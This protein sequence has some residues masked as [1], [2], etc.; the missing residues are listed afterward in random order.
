MD[1]KTQQIVLSAWEKEETT[2]PHKLCY[3]YVGTESGCLSVYKCCADL[4]IHGLHAQSQCLVCLMHNTSAWISH[5]PQRD[6]CRN[7]ACL[8][9]QP[10]VDH[11]A[12]VRRV[13]SESWLTWKQ[14]RSNCDSKVS[15]SWFWECCVISSNLEPNVI[16]IYATLF[17][18]FE[19]IFHLG[20]VFSFSP[21][22]LQS[23]SAKDYLTK[24]CLFFFFFLSHC[25]IQKILAEF[26]EAGGKLPGKDACTLHMTWKVSPERGY[27]LDWVFV[28]WLHLN[29]Q[30][31]S[32]QILPWNEL[33]CL[34]SCCPVKLHFIS[35]YRN[36]PKPCF[37]PWSMPQVGRQSLLISLRGKALLRKVKNLWRT[38]HFGK[39]KTL[40][41]L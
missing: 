19:C 13:S 5:M 26:S 36:Y 27:S 24:T 14:G 17:L 29:I 7:V 3:L 2:H 20:R 32:W 31:L 39:K 15:F 6:L 12:A 4:Q 40:H 30:L 10:W 22:F 1:L 16:I 18:L 34:A 11:G 21:K 25:W 41:A 8:G 35:L 9:C 28:Q 33:F 38:V 37:C 23:S